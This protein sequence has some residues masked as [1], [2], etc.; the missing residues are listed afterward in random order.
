M[1]VN[2]QQYSAWTSTIGTFLSAVGPR[3]FF[4]VIPLKLIE[5]DLN[6]LSYSQDSKSW[7]LPLIAQNSKGNGDLDF[8]VE[9][10][11]PM[12]LILT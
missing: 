12:I 3:T 8:Y 5:H 10:F 11:L 2:K 1:Q 6:S 7:L 9:Y 4:Q